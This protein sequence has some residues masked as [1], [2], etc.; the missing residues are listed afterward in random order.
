M[1]FSIITICYNDL[2]GLKMTYDSVKKQK[3]KDYEIIIIDGNST[4][5]TKEWLKNINEENIIWKSE[6]DKG[7]FDGMNKGLAMASGDYIIFMNSS[8]EFENSLVLDKISKRIRVC[9][10]K[11]IF[12]YG[13]SIDSTSEGK[14]LYK[15][16]RNYKNNW[17]GLFTSHQAMM[18][19]N[20]TGIRFQLKYSLAADYAY[21]AEYINL[22]NDENILELKFPICNFKLG[23]TN[24]TER[25]KALKEDFQ[26]R[27]EIIGISYYYSSLLFVLHFIHTLLKRAFPFLTQSIRY[28]S[29]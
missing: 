3:N 13:D 27:R 21:V 17:K 2:E 19:K 10:I 22:A 9:K 20:K 4:D 12:I 26:I 7:I 16:A 14:R 25:F 8:D 1:L 18:F 5:G 6:P 11:P 23:G 28:K 29:L 24:E 15:K